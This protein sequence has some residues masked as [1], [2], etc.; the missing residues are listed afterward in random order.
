MTAR[1]EGHLETEELSMRG[2]STR[3]PAAADEGGLPANSVSV[4]IPV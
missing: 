2:D 1:R 4:G 3:L